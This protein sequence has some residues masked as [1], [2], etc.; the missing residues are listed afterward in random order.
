MT[1][2]DNDFGMRCPACGKSH[3]IDVAATVWVRLCEDGTDVYEAANSGQEWTD[4]SAAYCGS[5]G[6]G[7]NVSD[8]SKAGGQP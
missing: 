8:F 5:C 6:H 4:N 7:G 3:R 1:G 2:I